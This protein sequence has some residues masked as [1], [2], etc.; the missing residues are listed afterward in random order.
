MGLAWS[1]P[2]EPHMV[3]APCMRSLLPFSNDAQWN[4]RAQDPPTFVLLS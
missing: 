1:V 3:R 4:S 2:S